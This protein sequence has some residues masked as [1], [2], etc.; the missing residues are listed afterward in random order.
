[1]TL[2]FDTIQLFPLLKSAVSVKFSRNSWSELT[3]IDGKACNNIP[4]AVNKLALSARLDHSC[5]SF[6]VHKCQNRGKNRQQWWTQSYDNNV[7]NHFDQIKRIFITVKSMSKFKILK[8]I[9]QS[10][11]STGVYLILIP[12]DLVSSS[13]MKPNSTM[14]RLIILWPHVV[15]FFW[16]VQ[17]STQDLPRRD[18]SVM[19]SEW[20]IWF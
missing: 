12:K 15:C 11:N 9:D 14:C 10:H 3:D 5:V 4:E 2:H 13:L 8:Y 20:E 17:Q 19:G 18:I 6:I 16:V 7:Q 1:M